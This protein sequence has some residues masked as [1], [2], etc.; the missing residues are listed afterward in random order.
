MCE[1]RVEGRMVP[2]VGVVR[3]ARRPEPCPRAICGGLAGVGQ[4]GGDRWIVRNRLAADRP[5]LDGAAMEAGGGVRI[6]GNPRPVE[7]GEHLV[8]SGRS[9][10]GSGRERLRTGGSGRDERHLAECGSDP[11]VACCRR[12]GRSRQQM[13]TATA[14]VSATT[15]G[16]TSSGWPRR[17]VSVAPRVPSWRSNAR[18][19]RRRYASRGRPAVRSRTSSSTNSGMTGPC[20][21]AATSA[22]WSSRRRSRRN[23]R[24]VGRTRSPPLPSAGPAPRAGR[25]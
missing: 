17:S 23:H 3:Q 24:T 9:A 13:W 4:R 19:V 22:G 6:V 8:G 25:R 20:R 15:E 14:P 12:T 16:T 5:P 1:V 2:A 18:S 10:S 7:R 11:L 21:A